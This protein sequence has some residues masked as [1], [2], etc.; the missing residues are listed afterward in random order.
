MVW[1]R[2]STQSLAWTRTV[3]VKSHDFVLFVEI[4]VTYLSKLPMWYGPAGTKL[5]VLVAVIC[6]AHEMPSRV[7][8][9]QFHPLC[10]LVPNVLAQMRLILSST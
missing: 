7:V 10:R 9:P 8:L 1:G 3:R 2:G 4:G 5:S 6:R